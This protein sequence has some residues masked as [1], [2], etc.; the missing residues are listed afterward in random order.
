MLADIAGGDVLFDVCCHSRPGVVAAYQFE[1]LLYTV[2]A[3]GSFVVALVK[4]RC[5]EVVVLWDVY[6][7]V[8]FHEVVVE[9]EML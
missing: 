3:G 5:A 9:R 8:V 7:V 1:S 2:M 6:E 4:E